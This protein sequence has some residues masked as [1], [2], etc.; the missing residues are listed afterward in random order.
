MIPPT[1]QQ[2]RVLWFSLTALAAGVVIGLLGLLVWG[3]GW[4][5]QLLSSVLLPLA[6]AAV[7]SY[8][9]DPVVDFFQRRGIPRT[10][11]IF[12]V[13]FLAIMLV[14]ML[15]ATVLPRLVVELSQ[16]IDQLPAYA[17][18]LRGRFSDWLAQSPLGMKAKDAWDKEMGASV[19]NFI[20]GSL[21][22]VTSWLWLQLSRVASWAGLLAGLALVP[23]YVF[24][25]LL[26][27]KGIQGNWTD[28]IPVR[29]PA[30]KKEIVFILTSI[31]DCLIVFFRGQVLVALCV[32][33][34]LTVLF[35]VIGLNYAFVL[36]LMAGLL[37]IVPYLGVMISIVPAV[38]LAMVQF[39]DWYHPALVVMAFILVQTAEG[40]FISP[41]IIG[42]RVGLHPLTIIVA[43]MTGT[44]L[45]GG[46]LGGVLAIPVTAA[47]RT[48]MMRYVWKKRGL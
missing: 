37:G 39:G 18:S 9:L 34:L 40:L 30:I 3:L 35:L 24:Y 16:L 42:D 15:A 28:Y 5:I 2:A 20:G 23:V 19:Q 43:V 22:V 6:I 45:L 47:L 44:T 4:L 41:K 14:L 25:F 46:I 7:I 21:P 38:L 32:G 10:R 11:A 36:G 17:E 29:D 26:E 8:L 48:L 12:M 27:K 31:N 1:E 33:G 13:F